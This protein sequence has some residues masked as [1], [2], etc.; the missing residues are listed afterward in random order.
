MPIL[1]E[2]AGGIATL[3][4]AGADAGNALT[5]ELC[6]ELHA[7]LSA[8]DADPSI[9]VMILRGAG[10][11][12]FSVGWDAAASAVLLDDLQTLQGVARHYVYPGAQQPLSPWIAWRTLLA[13][14]TVKPV[15]AAVRGDCLGLGLVLLGLHTD[16]RIA[17]DN[18]RFGFPD[19]HAGLGSAEALVSRLTRQ[20]PLAAVHWLVQTGWLFDAREA[21]R[22]CLVNEVVPD[23]RLEI[24]AQELAARIAAR[25]AGALRAEK[26]AAIHLETAGPD[27]AV[28]LGAALAAAE[29]G[30]E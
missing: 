12:S 19:I 17:A 20:I 6:V 18:A 30:A 9:R 5:P 21:R 10:H 27:D 29:A 4:I 3:A 22:H 28:A 7:A 2:A 13:Q 16:L 8:C 24:R 15:V 25:P 11:G 26:R 14:R 1:R 23:A